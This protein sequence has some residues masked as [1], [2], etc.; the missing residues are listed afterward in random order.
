MMEEQ[1]QVPRMSVEALV[2]R[3]LG[4][5][6]GPV[7]GEQPLSGYA[8]G[9]RDCLAAAAPAS[10]QRAAEARGPPAPCD[11]GGD[12]AAFDSALREP[13]WQVLTGFLAAQQRARAPD[14]EEAFAAATREPR[15]QAF[16]GFLAAQGSAAAAQCAQDWRLSG[17]GPGRV[18]A[19][20]AAL[21]DPSGAWPG[22]TCN[23]A[24]RSEEGEAAGVAGSVAAPS[25]GDKRP[26][27]SEA[28]SSVGG[29]RL[30]QRRR[31]QLPHLDLHG[32]DDVT[33]GGNP[34]EPVSVL[35]TLPMQ[36]DPRQPANQPAGRPGS[37]RARAS[38]SD[39]EFLDAQDFPTAPQE[40]A[41]EPPA[42]PAMLL[43]E[44]PGGARATIASP[45]AMDDGADA[46]EEEGELVDVHGLTEEERAYMDDAAL[47]AAEAE[48][49]RCKVLSDGTPKFTLE[50]PSTGFVCRVPLG[51]LQA[52]PHTLVKLVD[53]F[54]ARLRGRSK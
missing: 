20:L 16:A 7:D 38:S 19:R 14:C 37:P 34:D 29:R 52:R 25:V 47:W 32:A 49:A 41:G 1:Q 39:V 40:D 46:D 54:A 22:R 3:L 11:P 23:A 48:I 4:G 10:E 42:P 50:W 33:D 36:V 21:T 5:A 2:D 53:F 12:E 31:P 35:C 51:A 9:I 15:W 30:R 6:A 28:G 13:R 27:E 26:A 43:G 45:A 24:R 44:A 18:A 8:R 17:Q